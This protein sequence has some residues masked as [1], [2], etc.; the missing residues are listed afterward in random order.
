VLVALTR[1]VS[2]S[3]GNCEL[4][5]LPRVTIDVERARLEHDAYERAL[6]DAG[7][8]VER[9]P[10]GADIPD[11]VFIEDVAVVF[12]ELAVI[13]R[14]GAE[15][16]RAETAAVAQALGRY[17]DLH[18]LAAPATLDGGDVLVV[19][20][21]VFVGQS[22]RTNRDGIEQLGHILDRHDYTVVGVRIAGC[23]HLK[24]AA[25][26]VGDNLLLINPRW[27]S[28]DALPGADFVD[29]H[30]DEP[31]A[32]NALKIGDT[33]LYACTFARTRERLE[34]EGV[35]VRTVEVAELAKAEG[36]VTCCSLV[37]QYQKVQGVQKV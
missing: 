34:R 3:L 30:P 5:H 15:S 16:R 14:P 8:A 6:A 7:C 35:I 2:P 36:A 17:R 23:L 18:T 25:T 27:V 29:V 28:R 31:Y 1:E 10:A 37:F 22:V 32:A 11:S 19:G 13:T 4:V 26:A 21:T 12:D 33:V 9:L 20:R 24:S